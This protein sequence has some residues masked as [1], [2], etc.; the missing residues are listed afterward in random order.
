MRTGIR[1][2]DKGEDYQ[3]LT[4]F[5]SRIYISFIFKRTALMLCFSRPLNVVG[6]SEFLENFLDQPFI[7]QVKVGRIR[8]IIGN[9]KYVSEIPVMT[10]VI[11]VLATTFVAAVVIG[12]ASVL[13]IRQ[14]KTKADE[15]FEMELKNREEKVR[16][17]SR[18][19][20]LI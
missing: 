2:G 10:I 13:I 14:K 4:Q 18:E 16:D 17:A 19:G 1:N 12:V 9:L 15:N 11:A 20:T 3:S 8:E 6:S 7:F 5:L